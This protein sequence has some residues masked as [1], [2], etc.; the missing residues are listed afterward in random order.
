MFKRIAIAILAVSMLGVGTAKANDMSPADMMAKPV[1]YSNR[2]DKPLSDDAVATKQLLLRD[3]A[4]TD[5]QA[6]DALLSQQVDRPDRSKGL[7]LAAPAVPVEIDCCGNVGRLLQFG[8]IDRRQL[9]A[10]RAFTAAPSG[11]PDG[12][13][14]VFTH[15]TRNTGTDA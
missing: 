10:Q 14:D 6:T 4:Y 8:G 5:Q 15:C 7:V 9:A 11:S 1:I 3:H 12:G 13:L 2:C